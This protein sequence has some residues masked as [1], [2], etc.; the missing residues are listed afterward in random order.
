LSVSHT[1]L[2]LDND[3]TKPERTMRNTTIIFYAQEPDLARLLAQEERDNNKAIAQLRDA[4]VFWGEQ[5]NCDQVW[6]LPSVSNGHRDL[7]RKTYGDKI[8]ELTADDMPGAKARAPRGPARK[9]DSALAQTVADIVKPKPKQVST[10]DELRQ[11]TNKQ[12]RN[13]ALERGLALKGTSN[14]DQMIAALTE[15]AQT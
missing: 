2:H 1:Y 15:G 12:L 6:V 5:E 9:Q 4:A 13:L 14:R 11:L 10:N 8:V 3:P 7:L